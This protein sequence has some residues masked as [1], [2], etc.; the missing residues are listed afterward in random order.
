MFLVVVGA[1]AI[2]GFALTLL[3]ELPDAEEIRDVQLQVPLRVYA[4][5]GELM[6]EFGEQRRE[7]VAIADVPEPLVQAILAAEDDSFYSHPGVDFAG[8][9]RAAIENFKSGQTGQGASTITM[10]VARNY[11]LSREKTYTRKA[12]EALLAFRLERM[13]SKD[14]I[15]ELYINKI[16]LGHRAYGYAA[17]ARIYYGRRLDELTLPEMALLA[18]LPKAPSRDNPLTN[19]DRARERRNYVLGRMHKLGYISDAEYQEALDAPLTAERHRIT[20]DVDAPY[21]AEMARDYMV[22]RYGEE[23]YSSGYK[24]F[25]TVVPELQ[26]NANRALRAGLLDYSYRHGFT[27][28]VE[29]IE[30]SSDAGSEVLDEALAKHERS[31]ELLPAVVIAV[32]ER[33]ATVYTRRK[34]VV[35]I[36]WEGLSWARPRRGT[37]VGAEPQ[38]P[39]DVLAPGDIVYVAPVEENGWRLTQ[40]PQ[41]EGGL[42]SLD[43]RDGAI[44][45]LVG[46]FDFYLGKFNRI[47]QAERQPGSN[48]KP[49]IYSA[50]LE[51]G[52][53]P[54]TRV[55][56]GPIV[57]EDPARGELWRPE[58]YSGK[59][60]GPMPLR[61]ALMK[62]VNL[63]SVRVLRNIG[64]Q[65]AREHLARFGFDPDSLPNGLSL[66][67]GSGTVRPITVARAFGVVANGG[68]LVEPYFIRWVEDADGNILEQASPG[69]AC[70]YCATPAF[71]T[72]RE[73]PLQAPRVISPENRFLLT[74]MMRDVVRHGTGRR[75]MELGRNDLAGKTGT[76]NDFRDAW[77]S[78]FNDEFVTTVWVGFDDSR[79]LGRGEAGSRAALPIWVDYMEEALEGVPESGLPQPDNVVAARISPETGRLLAEGASG[80]T[81]EF[82]E[83]GTLPE[84]D[85]AGSGVSTSQPAGGS[86]DGGA[87]STEGLF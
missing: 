22:S 19:P 12:R 41:I 63:V 81:T 61:T 18:G 46:G 58:N 6:A 60:F 68:Y 70:G 23:A 32:E 53:T 66:A 51:H 1:L 5:N 16:F 62:S 27:G 65:N 17:A 56:G 2:G 80:G 52:Y 48:I 67:L 77:F 21:V 45:A 39:G 85:G 35:E 76:T 86:P 31:G 42:V 47:M 15:L 40:I 84:R 33:T 57:V 36:P 8:V 72:Q 78:G 24:V 83:I 69:I 28:P 13:L 79:T 43:P 59:F 34:E 14:Q 74:S 10:Q 50:A 64:L 7:P 54:A 49:F 75:A 29:R 44:R 26:H 87:I 82:F 4:A 25:T 55:S 73:R 11:F 20:T 37:G 9:V 3:P 38:S 30:L 71:E